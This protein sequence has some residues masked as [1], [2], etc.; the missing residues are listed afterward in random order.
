VKLSPSTLRLKIFLGM[1]TVLVG[2]A[3]LTTAAVGSMVDRFIEYEMTSSSVRAL[4][5]Y[6]EFVQKRRLALEEG[7]RGLARAPELHA[8]LGAGAAAQAQRGNLGE[9]LRGALRATVA[10]LAVVADARGKV[11]ADSR[12]GTGGR[13]LA[14]RPGMFEVLMGSEFSGVWEYAGEHHAVAVAPVTEGG[15]VIGLAAL[16][17]ALDAGAARELAALTGSSVILLGGEG[18]LPLAWSLEAPPDPQA[19]REWLEADRDRPLALE[20]VEHQAALLE[21]P[22]EELRVITCRARAEVIEPFLRARNEILAVGA[23]MTLVALIVS[24]QLSQRVGRPIQALTGR[25][26]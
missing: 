24:R 5:A 11:L 22:D 26:T 25:P 8:A 13:S 7:V 1:T 10:E 17:M 21:L 18:E 23:A 2:F 19:L 14:N 4:K 15:A 16:G 9:L 3:V 12:A 6:G 20:G